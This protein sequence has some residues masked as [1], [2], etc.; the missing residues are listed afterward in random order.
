MIWIP[1][2]RKKVLFGEVA[3]RVRDLLRRIAMRGN[4][5]DE[6]IKKYID[7]QE[8]D[9]LVDDSQFPIDQI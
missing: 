9:P 1:K 8:G 5:T 2:Y 4:V 6:M 7:G 3:I